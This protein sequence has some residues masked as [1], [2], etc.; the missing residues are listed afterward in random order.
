MNLD[1]GRLGGRQPHAVRNALLVLGAV[2]RGGPG[3]TVKQ[4]S[5]ELGLPPATTY[6]LV[7]L[8]AAEEYLV[9]LPDLH[10][11]ALGTRMDDLLPPGPADRHAADD[12]GPAATPARDRPSAID[13]PRRVVEVLAGP[14][15]PHTA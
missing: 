8:L 15:R 4:I 13:E 11:F 6:R 1:D 7:N 2:A 5:H 10:G 14:L 12:S 9:R 3:I